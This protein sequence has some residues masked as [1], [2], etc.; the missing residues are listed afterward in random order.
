MEAIL[1]DTQVGIENVPDI[2][3][4]KIIRLLDA[5]SV[6]IAKQVSHVWKKIIEHLEHREKKPLWRHICLRDIHRASLIDIIGFNPYKQEVSGGDEGDLWKNVYKSWKTGQ[7]LSF[8]KQKS[9]KL[10]GV[11]ISDGYTSVMQIGTYT[12]ILTH[13]DVMLSV[14]NVNTSHKVLHSQSLKDKLLPSNPHWNQMYPYVHNPLCKFSEHQDLSQLSL[15]IPAVDGYIQWWAFSNGG[16]GLKNNLKVEYEYVRVW[17]NLLVIAYEGCIQVFILEREEGEFNFR[18]RS[19]SNELR[20]D[21]DWSSMYVWDNRCL[22]GVNSTPSFVIYDLDDFQSKVLQVVAEPTASLLGPRIFGDFILYIIN[23]ACI[24]RL[25]AFNTETG[26][27]FPVKVNEADVSAYT[28]HGDLLI[29]LQPVL[30]EVNICRINSS[31]HKN[32][33]WCTQDMMEDGVNDLV[34]PKIFHSNKL[35]VGDHLISYGKGVV[36]FIRKY[37]V[38]EYIVK[39]YE[40]D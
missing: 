4:E 29:A 8:H 5:R 16:F 23:E 13:H 2:I 33:V 32:P 18:S 24:R 36:F 35:F 21:L 15:I 3:F 11:K 19:T 1:G 38:K 28:L 12:Y 10:T 17:H 20:E 14:W 30:G 6:L 31:G 39:H 37:N 27:Q 7:T 34:V 26:E 22:F 25:Y 40:I 9:H